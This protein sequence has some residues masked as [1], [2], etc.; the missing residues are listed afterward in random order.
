MF[1]VRPW[2][3]KTEDL[4]VIDQGVYADELLEEHDPHP[5]MCSLDHLGS[6]HLHPASPLPLEVGKHPFTQPGALFTTFRFQLQLR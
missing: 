6:E 1:V 3:P 5:H 4:P 2:N